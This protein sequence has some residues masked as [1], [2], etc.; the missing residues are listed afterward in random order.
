LR[1]LGYSGVAAKGPIFA[2]EQI[3]RAVEL[4]LGVD[5]PGKITFLTGDPDSAAYAS[6]I[7]EIM[8]LTG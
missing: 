3:A 5:G 2:Q 4:E 1:Y 6:R 8:N 7:Q